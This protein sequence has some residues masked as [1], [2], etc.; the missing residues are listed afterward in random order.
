LWRGKTIAAPTKYGIGMLD[1]RQHDRFNLDK[2][3][4]FANH[5]NHPFCYYGGSTINYS[6]SG[7]C[8]ISRYEVLPGDS[9]HLRLIGDH[10]Y[11]GTALENLSC[12]AEVK[13]CELIPLSD[14]PAYH[15]GLFYLDDQ[16]PDL[17]RPFYRSS[18]PHN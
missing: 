3:I 13:W 15:I 4:M 11:S 7:I 18:E 6:M 8:L 1:K 14:E 5:L 9:L 17:F 2:D 16:I 12:M 10:L